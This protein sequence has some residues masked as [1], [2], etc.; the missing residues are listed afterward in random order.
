[1]VWGG[2]QQDGTVSATTEFG[3][4]L[5][6]ACDR[7]RR[8]FPQPGSPPAQPTPQPPAPVELAPIFQRL[9]AIDKRLAAMEKPDEKPSE[10]KPDNTALTWLAML[11]AGTAAVVMYYRFDDQ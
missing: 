2:R 3:G 8:P 10:E 6:D 5:R 1:V 9:D 7:W 11:A 4:F